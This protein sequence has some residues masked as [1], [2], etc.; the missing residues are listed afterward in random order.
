MFL[1]VVGFV[2]GIIL[3]LKA[4]SYTPAS[5][6]IMKPTTWDIPEYQNLG[7]L[8][9]YCVSALD[10][11]IGDANSPEECWKMCA[12]KYPDSLAAIDFWYNE[13]MFDE[14]MWCYCQ[15]S[16]DCMREG[17]GSVIYI[18]KNLTQPLECSLL[19]CPNLSTNVSSP[20]LRLPSLLPTAS[21]ST[22]IGEDQF[23]A[24]DL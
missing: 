5:L 1:L 2:V 22:S 4:V 10:D 13:D 23:V 7:L 3:N 20:T 6:P 24:I 18:L 16:C 9:S 19:F 11:S 17:Y 8:D 21:P 12:S 14:D 15:D